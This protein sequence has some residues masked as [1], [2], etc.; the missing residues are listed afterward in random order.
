MRVSCR[1]DDP[2][3]DPVLCMHVKILC[4]GV[5]ITNRCYMADEEEGKAFCFSLNEKGEKF[6]NSAINAVAK[7]VCLGEIKIIRMH[8]GVAP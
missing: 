5:D 7:E 3:Y 1:K 8:N 6:F 4:D 2:G